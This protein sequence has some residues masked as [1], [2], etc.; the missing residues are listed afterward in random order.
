M[1][2]EFDVGDEFFGEKYPWQVGYVIMVIPR[3]G[4]KVLLMRKSMYPQ[5]IYRLPSGKINKGETPEAALVREGHEET[6]FDLSGAELLDTI[7]F[8][9]RH[10]A[11]M[12]TWTSYVF[13]TSEQAGE[14]QVLDADEKISDFREVSP[15]DLEEIARQL[16]NLPPG[17]W[18]DWGRFRAVEH[19]LVYDKFC[20]NSS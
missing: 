9:F 12:M 17:H 16:E 7:K 13:L 2:I 8:V 5:G 19:R 18:G 20:G 3:P 4:G 14:I 6:G 15:C 1:E 10:E 11:K